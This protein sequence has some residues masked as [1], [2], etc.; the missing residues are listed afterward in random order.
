MENGKSY[1]H[2]TDDFMFGYIMSEPNRCRK[3]LE[4]LLDIRI[5]HVEFL[6]KQH[7]IGEKLDARSVRLDIYL[8][9][10]KTVYDCEMQTT[11]GKDLPMRMRYYQSQIDTN[12]LNQ[13]ETY[14]KLKKS[15]IIF[16]CTFDFMK[17][18]RFIYTFT[19][20]CDEEPRLKFDDG[21]KKV[22]IN[23]RGILG[24][25]SREFKDL[26]YYFN[27][28]AYALKTDNAFIRE[29]NAAVHEAQADEKWRHEYMKWALIMND[30]LEEGFEKGEAVGRAKGKTEGRASLSRL[31]TL[32]S[33]AGRMDDIVKAASDSDYCDQLMKEFS[34]E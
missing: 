15:L 27:D 18:N 30:K 11:K 13:G 10:G 25:V 9:D 32:L 6:E 33:E 31:I 12:L 22:L 4:Q 5:D 14:E 26:M 23:T 24:S 28:P 29:L 7:A 20:H 17:E 21:T 3:F 16:I 1:I 19:Y 34:I 8:S 2:I